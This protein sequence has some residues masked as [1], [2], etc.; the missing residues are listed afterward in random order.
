MR[1]STI[2]FDVFDD[3]GNSQNWLFGRNA[4]N[5][6]TF[7]KFLKQDLTAVEET[8]QFAVS[9]PQ[10]RQSFKSI[11]VQALATF[12]EKYLKCER[13]ERNSLHISSICHGIV[14]LTDSISLTNKIQRVSAARPI[15]CDVLLVPQIWHDMQIICLSYRH[16]V[17]K[18]NW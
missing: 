17:G 12:S 11:I 2:N 1:N 16:I 8:P 18:I 7:M 15:Y 4:T 6:F 13:I 3:D 10:C 14:V 5:K 9:F